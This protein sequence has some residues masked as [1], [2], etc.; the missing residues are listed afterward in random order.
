[1][2]RLIRQVKNISEER[3][4]PY[5]NVLIYIM[6][7]EV[8]KGILS[9]EGRTSLLKEPKLKDGI[10][11]P[12]ED[13]K[14]SVYVE[15]ITN[16]EIVSAIQAE[17]L[18]TDILF[19]GYKTLRDRIEIVLSL[20]KAREAFVI[21]KHKVE[22]GTIYPDVHLIEDL[23]KPN[24]PIEIS[25]YQPEERVCNLIFPILEKLEL[26]NDMEVYYEIDDILSNEPLD[27]LKL[28]KTFEREVEKRGI[29]LDKLSDRVSKF[30]KYEG[31]T[32]LRKKWK[33]YLR[34]NRL[35][36]KEWKLVQKETL[37]FI[38]PLVT[39]MKNNSVFIDSW[40]PELGRYL[41]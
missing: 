24:K 40:L 37:A 23:L 35:G 18:K 41:G 16:E 39:A 25:L 3:H 27:G 32:F 8:V 17:M 15:D 22:E 5:P 19:E 10:L 21:E 36:K 11:N 4:I 7:C 30:S 13:N 9:C 38:E 26:M 1:M 34:V 31:N 33:A 2:E 14:L 28:F 29:S 20:D 6:K 12:K